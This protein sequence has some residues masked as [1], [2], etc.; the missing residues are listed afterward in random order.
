MPRRLWLAPMISQVGLV[1]RNGVSSGISGG[2][3]SNAFTT[4]M[5]YLRGHIGYWDRVSVTT[6][7]TGLVT[8]AHN[9]GFTPGAAFVQGIYDGVHPHNHYG[10]ISIVSLDEANMTI[11]MLR[12][13]GNDDAN[14]AR[15]VYYHILPVV[16][17]R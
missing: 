13:N 9:C 16:K 17:E 15:T 11:L 2:A 12:A 7:A 4:L 14:S 3:M 8:I 6:G 1:G 5:N 10:P